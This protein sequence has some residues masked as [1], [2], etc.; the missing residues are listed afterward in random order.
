MEL[1]SKDGIPHPPHYLGNHWFT[2]LISL[3]MLWWLILHWHGL[4]TGY[5][6]QE[7]VNSIQ[8]QTF[9]HFGKLQGM[10]A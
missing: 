10:M 9:V 3:T 1:G 8:I 5:S 4:N 7:G 6:I 2:E